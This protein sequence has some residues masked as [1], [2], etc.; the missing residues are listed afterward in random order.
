M[1]HEY[2]V[3]KMDSRWH[4]SIAKLVHGPF[5]SQ[6]SAE[7]AAIELAKQDFRV[8]VDARVTVE[9]DTTHVVYDN[10]MSPID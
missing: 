3:S 8:G 6:F 1:R 5:V 4:V 2:L 10:Q 7:M 9:G